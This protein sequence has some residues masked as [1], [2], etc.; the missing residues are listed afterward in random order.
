MLHWFNNR[1]QVKKS[2]LPFKL[3]RAYTGKRVYGLRHQAEV[4]EAMAKDLGSDAFNITAYNSALTKLWKS[5]DEETQKEFI[6]VA[7]EFDISGPDDDLKPEC[8]ACIRERAHG[9]SHSTA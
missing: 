7:K 2:R 5:L 8:V 3:R 4:R 6:E 1:I 9:Y